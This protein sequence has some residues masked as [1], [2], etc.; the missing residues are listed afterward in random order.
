MYK[1]IVV[2]IIAFLT[3]SVIPIAFAQDDSGSVDAVDPVIDAVEPDPEVPE[4]EP[5]ELDFRIVSFFNFLAAALLVASAV[6]T[7]VKPLLNKY[8]VTAKGTDAYLPLLLLSILG[9]S[10][11]EVLV[12]H[13]IDVLSFLPPETLDTQIPGF[14]E[15]SSSVIVHVASAVGVAAAASLG[16]QTLTRLNRAL[17]VFVKR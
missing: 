6:D 17:D 3:L 14:D 1:V 10:L 13:Q 12:S 11:F 4:E 15:D 8:P 7:S 16:H 9:Y 2:C 5:I